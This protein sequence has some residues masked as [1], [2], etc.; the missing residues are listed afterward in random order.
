MQRS[1]H[2][3]FLLPAMLARIGSTSYV[4]RE[5][6]DPAEV[7]RLAAEAATAR[8][9]EIQKAVDLAVLGLKSKNDELLQKLAENKNKLKEFDGLNSEELKLLKSKIDSDEDMKLL[10]EGK[11]QQVIEKYTERMRK[12][13][14]DELQVER[15]K[16]A[17]ES[18]RADTYRG[19]VL[20]NQIRAAA[21]GLHAGAIEDALLHA[22]QIFSLDAKG[23]AVKVDA[24]GRPELGKDG[25]TPFSPKEWMEQQ[26]ELKPHWF[27]ST[28][29]GSNDGSR[30]TPAASGTGKTMKRSD[31]DK[32]PVAQQ[33][34]AVVKQQ[35]RIID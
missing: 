29:T 34:E 24:E 8:Q 9:A 17:A 21:N 4:A 35:T 3:N 30:S 28:T 5:G 22:R 19:S 12:N 2:V 25:T 11:T 14:L 13:H 10:S 15:E 27:P 16:T 23:N 1:K 31:F 7:A 20:D 26:K 32:L 33:I 6:E 18:R